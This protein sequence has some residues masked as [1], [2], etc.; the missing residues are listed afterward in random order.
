MSYNMN[1]TKHKVHKNACVKK[2][3]IRERVNIDIARHKTNKGR[4]LLF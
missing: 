1:Y 2:M 4:N 3:P